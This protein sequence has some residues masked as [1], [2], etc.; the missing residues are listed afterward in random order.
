MDEEFIRRAFAVWGEAVQKVRMIRSKSSGDPAGYCFVEFADEATAERCLR[1]VN[2]KPLP[3]A[4]PPK[5]F[6]LNRAAYGRQ[7]ENSPTFSLFVSDL[8]PDVDDGMLYEFFCIHFPSCCSGKIVL[9]S[10]GYSKCCGFVSFTSQ[11]DHRRALAEFQGAVGLGK[12][13]LRLHLATS[14]PSKKQETEDQAGFFNAENYAR[15]QNHLHPFYIQQYSSYYTGHYHSAVDNDHY[16]HSQDPVQ[17]TS[18][19]EEPECGAVDESLAFGFEHISVA[20]VDHVQV[21][22]VS[23]SPAVTV[24]SFI[25]LR[26]SEESSLDLYNTHNQTLSPSLCTHLT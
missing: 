12:K 17:D 23:D 8:S 11:R 25:S 3:G 10:E 13:P 18:K 15:S 19:D 6:K 22:R 16:T 1:R 4:A 2:G 21:S 7:V 26:L 5:R 24:L 14:K 9:N 20:Q